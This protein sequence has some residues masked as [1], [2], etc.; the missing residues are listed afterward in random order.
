M[1]D[2]PQDA[3]PRA[4]WPVIAR[5]GE[6]A[7]VGVM[8]L[9]AEGRIVWE[10][11]TAHAILGLPLDEPSP[12]RGLK[13]TEM[14][15]VQAAGAA[16]LLRSL[17]SGA[18]VKD[19][20]IDIT[21]IT[22][23]EISMLMDGG[24]VRGDDGEVIGA[25]LAG[26]DLSNDANQAGRLLALQRMELLGLSVTGVIH[27]LNNTLT[28]L[29]GALELMRGGEQPSHTLLGGLE[30]MV[31]RSQD[32]A[33]RLLEV[34]R[35]GNQDLQPMD[36]RTPVRQAADLMRHGLGPGIN[37][38]CELP[39]GQVPVE[40]ART[41][42]LQALFNLGT[43]ARDAMDGTGS[44]RVGL[45]SVLDPALCEE[46]GWDG[47]RYAR[48]TFSDSG[49]GI[50]PAMATRI[51]EPFFTTKGGSGT[52]MGLAVVHRAVLDHSGLIT[53][54]STDE[55]AS[56]EIRL[57]MFLGLVDDDEPTRSMVVPR[58]FNVHGPPLEGQRVLVADDEPALRLVLDSG[59]AVKGAEVTVVPDG[60]TA[61]VAAGRALEEG[62]P[63]HSALVDL[64]MPGLDGVGLLSELRA[65]H[66]NLR[67]VATSGLE[68]APA[69]MDEIS[70]LRATFLP[71]P[72]RLAH[73]VE[74]LMNP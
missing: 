21:S 18:E 69:V 67:L 6:R 53:L 38:E 29:S 44:I 17:T 60:S 59:L 34:S 3:V 5:F 24:A 45:S 46:M 58:Q 37:I 31:R 65:R 57:P 20:L 72:F 14:A 48:I 43:N 73:V 52:G 2:E 68:P 11:R 12:T 61:L 15:N 28:G 63:Y 35:P 25:W 36:L 19:I 39:R 22:G 74:A 33:A 55:G 66:P 13:I 71:K 51:W 4:F 56:F 62:V 42:L 23:R 1:G 30:G 9:D 47:N 32:I 7:P 64:H 10:N 54:Q 49:P 26:R 27:D 8:L 50:P 40:C 41:N 70:G 16:A